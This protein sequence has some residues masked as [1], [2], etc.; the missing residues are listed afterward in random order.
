M[1]DIFTIEMMKTK[2]GMYKLQDEQ[3]RSGVIPFKKKKKNNIYYAA[4]T[5]YIY[6]NS[7]YSWIFNRFF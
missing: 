5:I 6:I 7:K 1:N 3:T 4:K 2:T